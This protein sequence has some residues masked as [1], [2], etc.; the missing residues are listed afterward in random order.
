VEKSIRWAR[1]VLL[2]VFLLV[3]SGLGSSSAISA[4]APPARPAGQTEVNAEDLIDRLDG[5]FN[6]AFAGYCFNNWIRLGDINR[7]R[8]RFNDGDV[9]VYVDPAYVDK[10][11]A[12]ALYVDYSYAGLEYFND[13]VLKDVPANV[14]AQTLWHETMHAIFDDHDSEIANLGV[15]S[16]E[17]YTW[18]MEQTVNVLRNSLPLYENELKKGESC[19]SKTL[20]G[21]WN[22]FV[23]Q[24]EQARNTGD[25]GYITD[26]Q[27][28]QVEALTGFR[29]DVEEI[30]Q[31]YASGACGVC[32]SPTPAPET[33]LDDLDLIFC[34]DV[35]G[36]MEDDIASV[37]AAASGI[38]NTIAAKNDNFR[39][40]IVA[41][42]DW[43]DSAGYA[44]FEDYA[45]SSNKD[46]I[47]ANINSLSVGGGD[48]EPEAVFEALMRAIDSRA[49]GG[50]RDNVNKQLIV[51][52]DAPPHNPS[53]QGYTAQIVAKAAWD[54]DPVIIQSVVVANDGLYNTEAVE[55]FRELAE[56][57]DG[58]FFEA[59]NADVVPEVLQK[60]IAVIETPISNALKLDK[61]LLLMGAAALC[62]FGLFAVLILLLLVRVSRRKRVSR[63][64]RPAAPPS[65][66]P[67]PSPGGLGIAAQPLPAFGSQGHDRTVVTTPATMI[68]LVFV[69]GPDAGRRFPLR[70]SNRLGRSPDNEVVLRDAQVSRHH[71][72]IT[73]SNAGY[74]IT[75]LG[76]ANGTWVNGV[77]IAQPCH[78]RPGDA[79]VLGANRLTLQNRS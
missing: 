2:V 42:R 61:D 75:D 73:F 43:E 50:W 59:E 29:V 65:A 62:G 63:P 18:Y 15:A 32:G 78:L 19:D 9:Q 21:R 5:W 58:N 64:A 46:A 70:P 20:Q 37:K 33:S 6:S 7:V 10:E 76:S 14:A 26:E 48:D 34:I 71:A 8:E 45:F 74:T 30:R 69:E 25:S 24:M 51:M 68:E 28:R 3:A 54:A 38:V 1:C 39:V 55:A 23:K 52:G 60:S 66:T 35:T 13:I 79:I 12:G 67:V 31:G 22:M 57:T 47:I 36:S 27:I 44:M 17:R 11:D 53:R 72:V 41:Y 56:L 40:A 16:D 77:R 4:A 49:V